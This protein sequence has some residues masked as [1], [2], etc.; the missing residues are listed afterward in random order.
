MGF[1]GHTHGR[2]IGARSYMYQNGR[3]CCGLMTCQHQL[4]D[5][6][7]GDGGLCLIPGSHKANFECPF[8]HEQGP[9]I[10]T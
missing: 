10:M 5:V 1:H 6:N 4:A 9:D 7:P 8:V 3:M 2:F